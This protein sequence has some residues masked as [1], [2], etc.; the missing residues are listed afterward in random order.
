MRRPEEQIELH[1]RIESSRQLTL[2]C[3]FNHWSK[4]ESGDT[5]ENETSEVYKDTK[6]CKIS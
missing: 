6:T 3:S 1:R 5:E 2:G 4:T